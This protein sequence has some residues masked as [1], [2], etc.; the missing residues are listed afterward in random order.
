MEVLAAS[1]AKLIRRPAAAAPQARAQRG[2]PTFSG[3][4]RVV[5]SKPVRAA[6]QFARALLAAIRAMV[7][8]AQ[9]VKHLFM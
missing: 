2:L 4:D 7:Q 3:K 1:D 5:L 9:M 8:I 6:L